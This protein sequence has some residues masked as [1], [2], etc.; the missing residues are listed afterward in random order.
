[1]GP[2][3]F[4]NLLVFG[5]GPSL[6]SLALYPAV[7]VNNYPMDTAISGPHSTHKPFLPFSLDLL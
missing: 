6:I 4:F 7:L 1:M 2:R 5:D 3:L